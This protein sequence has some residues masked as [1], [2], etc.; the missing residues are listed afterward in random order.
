VPVR[1]VRIGRNPT[2]QNHMDALLC[3]TMS[4]SR[5]NGSVTVPDPVI[6]LTQ[7]QGKG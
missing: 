4:S 6:G 7:E 2:P 3:V 5:V 1:D